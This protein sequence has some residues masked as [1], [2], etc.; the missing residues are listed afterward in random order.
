MTATLHDVAA[1][2]GVSAI[3][4]SRALN[5]SGYV[6]SHTRQRILDAATEL[7]YVPNA[8]ASSLRSQRT[9]LLA[10]LL[11]DVTNPFWTTVARGVEDTA[12]DAGYAVILCNTDE[13][14]TKE[15]RYLDLL[16]RRRID[17][18]L[19]A[20]TV[21]STELLRTLKRRKVPF[22]LI[23]RQVSGLS[24][25]IVRG[26][27][28]TGAYRLTAHLLA[29]G[30]R[31]IAMIG[32]P[33]TV[34]TGEDRVRGYLTALQ[35]AGVA[36][37]EGLIRRGPYRQAWGYAAMQDLLASGRRPAAIFAANNVIALGVLEALRAHDLRVPEDV[38]VVSFD[39]F[40]PS[41]GAAPFLT[42]AVQPAADLG[43]QAMR[44]LLERLAYPDGEPRDIV[45]PTE[46]VVRQS[47]GCAPPAPSAPGSGG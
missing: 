10:L 4:V 18:L 29:T 36:P 30:Y 23:D 33:A 35:D 13:D 47:C 34:S 5:N 1:K 28:Y 9:Q 3:T 37:D 16:L 20:P 22:V 31:Q 7:N 6:S 38:A 14:P 21:E 11:T 17:G 8:L 45:L 40:P 39:D 32:G 15:A 42:A 46:L 12:I 43:R 26:D 25:D 2:A 41:V 24:A 44:L 19:I 27:S